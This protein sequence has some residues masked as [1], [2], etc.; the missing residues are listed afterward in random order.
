MEDEK[1]NYDEFYKFASID[2]IAGIITQNK[3]E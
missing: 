1:Y 3:I 2:E